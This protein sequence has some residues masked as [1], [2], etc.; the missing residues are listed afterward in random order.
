MDLICNLC[1]KT[2]KKKQSLNIHLTNKRCKSHLL[3]NL[4]DLNNYIYSQKKEIE[5]LKQE[6]N[7]NQNIQQE[8]ITQIDF[9]DNIT[10]GNLI[11]K[12]DNSKDKISKDNMYVSKIK[13][14]KDKSD[15]LVT[16]LSECIINVCRENE[17]I[18]YI[19]KRPPT[20]LY[21]IENIDGKKSKCIKGLKDTILLL[22]YP[23]LKQFKLKFKLSNIK[24]LNDLDYILYKDTIKEIKGIIDKN[25]IKKVLN[26]VLKYEILNDINMKTDYS[27]LSLIDSNKQ[28][29][30]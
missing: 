29:V 28:D 24:T 1:E 25:I 8:T 2:F 18:K 11:K 20:Y 17:C 9:I 16:M 7:I 27:T 23:I 3:L 13:V 26:S 14:S 12:Y 30:P 21:T 10:L 5:K 19:K 4:C 15:L 6:S 22:S